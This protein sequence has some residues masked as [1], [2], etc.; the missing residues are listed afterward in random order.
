MLSRLSDCSYHYAAIAWSLGARTR[1]SA[2]GVKNE[3]LTVPHPFAHDCRP[4]WWENHVGLI[5]PSPPG[6]PKGPRVKLLYALRTHRHPPMSGDLSAMVNFLSSLG[7]EKHCGKFE[8]E[9]VDMGAVDVMEEFDYKQLGVAKVRCAVFDGC[10]CRFCVGVCC[11]FR[12]Q[13]MRLFC[14]LL[15]RPRLRLAVL[16]SE[17]LPSPF[18]LL[19]VCYSVLIT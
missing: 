11:R 19:L 3:T 18:V 13:D 6:I 12:C 15:V 17:A 14:V 8:E 9:E 7:L 5:Y 1:R 2:G 4:L 16:M 10:R